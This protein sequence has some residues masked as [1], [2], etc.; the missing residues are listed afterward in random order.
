MYFTYSYRVGQYIWGSPVY[1]NLAACELKHFI[2]ATAIDNISM[3]TLDKKNLV[4]CTHLSTYKIK[5]SLI[6]HQAKCVFKE[7]L[8]LGEGIKT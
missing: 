6:S 8:M 1:P 7:P 4:Y 3:R 2:T 5:I